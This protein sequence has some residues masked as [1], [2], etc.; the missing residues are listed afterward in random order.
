MMYPLKEKGQCFL[1]DNPRFCLVEMIAYVTSKWLKSLFQ[2]NIALY[3]LEN[4]TFKDSLLKRSSNRLYSLGSLT[5][6][7]Y[8][9]EW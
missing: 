6:P 5:L 3:S 2:P 7:L 8:K 9:K 1:A 4:D